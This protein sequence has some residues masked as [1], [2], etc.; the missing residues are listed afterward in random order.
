MSDTQQERSAGALAKVERMNRALR[1]E[2][3]DRVPMGE[4][5]W[6]GFLRRWRE[7]LGLPPDA[8]PYQHYDLDWIV[9]VPNMDRTSSLSRCSRR[10]AR[11]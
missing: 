3:P 11:R 10:A 5:Y 4:F 1:H 7:E 2:E 8:D 9:T 6:G